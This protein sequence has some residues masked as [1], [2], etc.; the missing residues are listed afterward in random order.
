M[1]GVAWIGPG[2][3]GRERGKDERRRDRGERETLEIDP[4]DG[5]DVVRG[6]REVLLQDLEPAARR[7]AEVDDPE[8]HGILR[9]ETE[10]VL[11]LRGC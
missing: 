1:S 8:A 2:S 4:D 6:G 11:D 7:C 3:E 5:V 10:L 9:D